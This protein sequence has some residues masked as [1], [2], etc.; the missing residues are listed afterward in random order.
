MDKVRV[1]NIKFKQNPL[2]KNGLF[3]L[4][5]TAKATEELCVN[6][7]VALKSTA[8]QIQETSAVTQYVFV[9]FPFTFH[10]TTVLNWRN[11]QLCFNLLFCVI[12]KLRR[13]EQ[14]QKMHEVQRRSELK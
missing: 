8:K 13:Q 11:L 5:Y 2:I 10:E 3:R 6:W 4:T 12:L 14:K 7:H 9:S 1:C